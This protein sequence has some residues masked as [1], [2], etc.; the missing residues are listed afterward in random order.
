NDVNVAALGEHLFG[1]AKG[2][3]CSVF[4][5]I[6]TGVGFSIVK[7]GKIWRGSHNLAGQIAHLQLFDKGETVNDAFSGKGISQSASAM[8]GQYVST[9]DV[10]RLASEG[11]VEAKQIIQEATKKAALTIAWIQNT[12]DPDVFIIGGGVA[13]SEEKFLE[14]IRRRAGQLLAKYEAQLPKG[15]SFRLPLLGSD[16]GLVGCVALFANNE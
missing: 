16:A 14:Q 13:L 6:S 7:D 15:L 12:I 8:L 10:F 5:V 11:K 3:V 2:V 9:E 1:A 4:M